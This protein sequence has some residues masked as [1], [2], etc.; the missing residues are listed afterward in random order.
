MPY[1]ARHYDN[2]KHTDTF[3][4][5]DMIVKV[6]KYNDYM[7]AII[8]INDYLN[9]V[10]SDKISFNK[11]TA[12]FYSLIESVAL[13]I[14]RQ[15]EYDR[16]E[17]TS[18]GFTNALSSYIKKDFEKY[19]SFFNE[20]DKELGELRFNSNQLVWKVALKLYLDIKNAK[21]DKTALKND[22]DIK[23]LI[24]INEFSEKFKKATASRSNSA[25]LE[26]RISNFGE[27]D[28]AWFASHSD[29][30]FD[31]IE[32]HNLI[33]YFNDIKI[34]LEKEKADKLRIEKEEQYKVI[35]A[36][37]DKLTKENKYQKNT[38]SEMEKEIAELK[39]QVQNL[40]KQVNSPHKLAA[41]DLK[42]RITKA[43]KVFGNGKKSLL[44]ETLQ[45]SK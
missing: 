26:Q 31:I 38:I 7:E 29:I 5:N 42:H 4:T 17:K 23:K 18:G 32:L 15:K 44:Q 1:K 25:D 35:S 13:A 41:L 6:Q 14:A 43:T 24:N 22:V 2:S 28:I 45:N 19:E 10:Q 16:E 3:D 36:N 37:N 33:Q 20:T 8:R 34:A 21:F 27:S 40:S 9:N 12:P 11:K 39:K 30:S